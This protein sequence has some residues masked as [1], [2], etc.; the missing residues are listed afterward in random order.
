[1][2]VMHVFNWLSRGVAVFAVLVALHGILVHAVLA[3]EPSAFKTLLQLGAASMYGAG[4]ALIYPPIYS[5]YPEGKIHPRALGAAI[6]LWAFATY[7]INP[8]GTGGTDYS[9]G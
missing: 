9:P 6:V 1:M 7:M 3:A 8:A 5:S 2:V 4:A